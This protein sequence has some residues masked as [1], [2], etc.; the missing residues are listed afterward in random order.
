MIYHFLEIQK[1]AQ[2]LTKDFK[3]RNEYFRLL[4][5]KFEKILKRFHFVNESVMRFRVE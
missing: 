3:M 2:I 1:V 5:L 4:S